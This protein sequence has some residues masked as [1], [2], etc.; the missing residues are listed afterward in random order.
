V[1]FDRPSPARPPGEDSAGRA[2]TAQD[3]TAADSAQSAQRLGPDRAAPGRA[4]GERVRPDFYETE[5]EQRDWH[6]VMN[7]ARPPE[8]YRTWDTALGKPD[9][10]KTADATKPAD[11]RKP[12]DTGETADAGETAGAGEAGDQEAGRAWFP[13]KRGRDRVADDSGGDSADDARPRPGLPDVV[14]CY[15]GEYARS[16]KKPPR[17]DKPH[18]SPEDWV[19]DTNS[20]NLRRS[21]NSNCG[22]CARAVDSTWHGY[23]TVAAALTSPGAG[24]E[25]IS[26]MI[27]WAGAEPTRASM[28]DVGQRLRELGPGSSALV[29]CLWADREGGHWFNGLNDAGTVKAVDGQSGEVESWPPTGRGLGFDQSDMQDSCAIF[30]GPDGKVKH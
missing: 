12:A 23:P 13:G 1:S 16:D 5:E 24:G 7:S 6:R 30:F 17:V 10:A 19:K 8:M 18:T 25:K 15:P 4:P 26:R 14:A 21:R 20:G 22:E 28:A 29:A 27:E 9:A 2:G 11:T 3:G